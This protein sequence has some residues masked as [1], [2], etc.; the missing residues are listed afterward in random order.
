MA[1]ESFM[2]VSLK[3]DQSK[4]LAQVISNKTARLMLDYLANREFSTETE[5]GEELKVPLSTIHYNCKALVKSGLVVA[6][7]FHYSKKGKEV[8][9][10]RLA[11]KFIIIAPKEE[12]KS[13]LMDRL[14][15]FLPLMALAVGGAAVIE[16]ARWAR[17]R[18]LN[19]G[20]LLLKGAELAAD[21]AQGAAVPEMLRTA[22][23]EAAPVVAPE[24]A[25]WS[26]SPLALGFLIG[27]LALVVAFAFYEY[28]RKK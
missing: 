22:A 28:M 6:D 12:A 14:K 7:E 21:E 10:Y 19:T 8:P 20:P 11:K 9:H 2:L 15:K 3:E 25:R 1:E 27:G 16:V 23:A 5:M 4:D 18:S 17:L 24:V 13:T 26:P